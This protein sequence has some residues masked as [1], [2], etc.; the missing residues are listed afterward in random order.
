MATQLVTD[1]ASTVRTM[2]AAAGLPADEDE[3]AALA[4]SY[5][6]LREQADD[7]Y[8]VD[9]DEPPGSAGPGRAS[10]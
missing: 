5:A 10:A 6:T 9:P 2:L 8:T 4:S 7:L 1:D 3:I